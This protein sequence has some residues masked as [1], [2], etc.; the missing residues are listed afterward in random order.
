MEARDLDAERDSHVQGFLKN[1]MVRD[2][3]HMARSRGVEGY[4]TMKKRDLAENLF[5]T[6]FMQ[7]RDKEKFTV[8]KDE[9]PLPNFATPQKGLV[10]RN[11]LKRF[12]YQAKRPGAEFAERFIDMDSHPPPL[13][14][15]KPAV[16]TE[17][18]ERAERFLGGLT[19]DN[20]RNAGAR[21]KIK[22]YS[23]MRRQ[24]LMDA[25]IAKGQMESEARK[26]R[27]EKEDTKQAEKG[28]RV[29][30]RPVSPPKKE[31]P[32]PPPKVSAPAAVRVFR[33]KKPSP[34]SAEA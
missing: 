4:K 34:E 13:P 30:R 16:D 9:A 12:E 10:Q 20:L 21:M 32:A 33:R 29:F 23:T 6:H 22:G 5:S 3:R 2:L 14:S 31:E 17:R 8:E 11:T 28:V 7:K 19:L 27:E 1:L 26:A 18:K 15:G 24:D 25:I